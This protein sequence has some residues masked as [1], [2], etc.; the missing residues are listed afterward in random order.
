MAQ[1]PD[2]VNAPFTDDGTSQGFIRFDIR[3]GP[4]SGL[5]AGGFTAV[6]K[7]LNRVSVPADGSRVMLGQ[8]LFTGNSL[9]AAWFSAL[10]ASW[11]GTVLH[12][13]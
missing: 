9:L 10:S 1:S 13:L 2:N 7:P 4:A 12:R 6:P 11:R 3:P 5:V 8:Y